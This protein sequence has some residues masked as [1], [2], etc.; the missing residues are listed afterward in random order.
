MKIK[1]GVKNFIKKGVLVLCVYTIITLCLM[2]ATDRIERL[3]R[4]NNDFR[5]YNSSVS[6]NFNK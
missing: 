2:M 4:S 1:K 6:L 5:N 3:D